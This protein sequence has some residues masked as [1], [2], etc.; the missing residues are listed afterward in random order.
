MII[1]LI[2]V[3]LF[4][5][6]RIISWNRCP[7]KHKEGFITGLKIPVG[8]YFRIHSNLYG[9]YLVNKN[10]LVMADKLYGN[11]DASLWFLTCDNKLGNKLGG[12]I[13]LDLDGGLG[14]GV[15]LI[16]GPEHLA[17]KWGINIITNKLI[18][19]ETMQSITIT[20]H[21]VYQNKPQKAYLWRD[22]SGQ[23]GKDIGQNWS[24]Q[25]VENIKK[26]CPTIPQYPADLAN[27]NIK[28]IQY[29]KPTQLGTKTCY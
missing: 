10:G 19:F 9:K 3:L 14:E 5:L 23:G 18:N 6:F 15:S 26:S 21:I 17:S 28:R 4:I 29:L 13:S 12:F 2:I 8:K 25:I 27:V 16:V 22:L 11:S 24:I 1:A 20:Y 7:C